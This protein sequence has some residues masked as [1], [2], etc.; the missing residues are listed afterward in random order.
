MR[1]LLLRIAGGAALAAVPSLTSST[2]DGHAV[3]QRIA[4][5]SLRDTIAAGPSL[6][7]WP[8]TLPERPRAHAP[9]ITQLATLDIV[10][11]SAYVVLAPA[12]RRRPSELARLHC[13]LPPRG[14]QMEACAQNADQSAEHTQRRRD[15]DRV[16]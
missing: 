4:G 9:T 11:T 15:P 12:S 13:L 8:V 16:P 10:L 7:R 5:D 3:E 14:P 6:A 1:S 2:S